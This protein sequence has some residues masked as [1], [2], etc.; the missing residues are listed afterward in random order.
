[1]RYYRS[2]ATF[3]IA[4]LLLVG[5][6]LIPAPSHQTGTMTR[7]MAPRSLSA[8]LSQTVNRFV[9]TTVRAALYCDVDFVYEGYQNFHSYGGGWLENGET[10]SL[11]S[12]FGDG[13]S[14]TVYTAD[15]QSTYT[16]L[17][18]TYPHTYQNGGYG[19][20]VEVDTDVQGFCASLNGSV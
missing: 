6:A 7:I 11:Y 2:L 15:S 16:Y 20:Y 18:R 13:T 19:W 4:A 9:V 17:D 10:L 5:P 8:F 1:M 3:V 14:D 12:D